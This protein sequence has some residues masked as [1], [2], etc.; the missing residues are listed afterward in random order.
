[1]LVC[2]TPTNS[3]DYAIEKS[4]ETTLW[5]AFG[6]PNVHSTTSTSLTYVSSLP[7][8]LHHAAFAITT[9]ETTLNHIEYPVFKYATSWCLPGFGHLYLPKSSKPANPLGFWVEIFQSKNQTS[10]NILLLGRLLDV[11]EK[12]GATRCYAATLFA[13]TSSKWNS[14]GP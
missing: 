12:N 8:P 3:K 1:M 13:R 11:A 4:I 2:A 9:R 6:Q 10:Q 14:L 7:S 5:K